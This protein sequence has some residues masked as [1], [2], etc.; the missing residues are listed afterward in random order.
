MADLLEMAARYID[1][2]VADGSVNRVTLE[3]SEVAA[4][5][6][7]VEAFSHVVAF[8]TEDGL[9]L[10]DC[11]LEAFGL[12]AGTELRRWSDQPVDTIVYTHGH[13]DHVGGARPLINEARDRNQRRPVI[14]GHERI[15]ARFD[16]YDLTNGYNAIVNA[17]QFRGMGLLGS[18]DES[19]PVF[20][21]QWVR[22]SITYS[23]ALQLKVGGLDIELHHGLGETDD[24]TWAWIPSR[25]AVCVG[26]FLTWVFPNAGNPQKVQRYPLE[27][28]QVLREIA[29]RNPELLLPAHGLPIAG[30]DRIRTVL[31][32]VATA[33]ELLV[34]ETLQLMNDGATL[35]Q[36]VQTVRLP[37]DLLDKPYLQP[38][39]D[40]PEFVI[41]NIWRLYGGWYDGNPAR[42]KPPADN[43]IGMEMANLVGGVE[44]L[45]RK[46][47]EL[48]ANG[49]LAMAAHF[50]ELAFLAAPDDAK[51]HKARARIYK[52]RRYEE[53]S[54]M[55]QGIFG[56]AAKQSERAL[57][58][59]EA[60]AAERDARLAAER[61]Q[62]ELPTDPGPAAEAAPAAAPRAA[63]GGSSRFGFRTRR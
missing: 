28:A 60:Q 42:L 12:R 17:R 18:A 43:A 44:P 34:S 29:A 11:S 2:G 35:D 25:R 5:V 15:G 1:S 22:P 10:F 46:A 31:D 40:E 58:D 50:V 59:L 37:H 7:L 45:V 19:R 8:E 36:I 14:V 16:R 54:L 26:D 6:A 47:L 39:Y 23:Q 33:L 48:R 38:T 41:R 61:E 4:G 55:A 53:L 21:T 13:A 63:S 49:E 24:H 51:V 52:E 30:A 27:W 57:E 56:Y 62:A 9:V 32:D 3:L 20:P